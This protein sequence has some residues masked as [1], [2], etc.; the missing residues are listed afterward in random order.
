M[1][2]F[3]KCNEI[4]RGSS[5]IWSSIGNAYADLHKYS[6]AIESFD[7][8]LEISSSDPIIWMN[9][10]TC[11]W[12]AL[13]HQEAM[14]EYLVIFEKYNLTGLEEHIEDLLERVSKY[15]LIDGEAY[16]LLKKRFDALMK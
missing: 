11:L 8:S 4:N 9:K 16:L 12:Q 2:Y 3:L 6:L 5:I 1:S 7:R 15:K 13:R 14:Q 10:A